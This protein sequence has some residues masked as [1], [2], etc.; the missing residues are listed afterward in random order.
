MSKDRMTRMMQSPA[1]IPEDIEVS[2]R[3][4][5]ERVQAE[6]KQKQ[7]ALNN[8]SHT[9]IQ[10]TVICD[11]KVIDGKENLPKKDE[12]L[13]ESF[14]QSDSG[15]SNS[16]SRSPNGF[17]SGI[18]NGIRNP[19]YDSV[20]EEEKPSAEEKSK[21]EESASTDNVEL[22]LDA[23]KLGRTY[24]DPSAS[25]PA[26]HPAAQVTSTPQPSR[27]K[28]LSPSKKVSFLGGKEAEEGEETTEPVSDTFVYEGG[29]RSKFDK[30][31]DKL[32]NN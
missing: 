27:G 12:G 30:L 10:T 24:S 11:G 28:K 19:V 1:P 15:D 4:A 16:N 14:E 6:E 31:R 23:A 13:G 26:K 8:S 3:K 17:G 20:P 7:H 21:D 2:R 22:T 32:S 25:N 18:S 29:K 5:L 9:V